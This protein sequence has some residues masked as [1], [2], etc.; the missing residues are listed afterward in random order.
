[1]NTILGFL[2]KVTARQNS[3]PPLRPLRRTMDGLGIVAEDSISR[4]SEIIAATPGASSDSTFHDR[5]LPP[6]NKD[7]CPN[8][9]PFAVRVGGLDAFTTARECIQRD[10]TIRGK[11]A[12]LNLASDKYRAGGW[13]ES[14]SKTQVR[15]RNSH[16]QPSSGRSNKVELSAFHNNRKRRYATLP[17]C[18]SPSKTN[19]THGQTSDQVQM[20]EFTPR[21][22]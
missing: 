8:F 20:Q 6:L 19:T 13:R 4:T 7:D 10:S 21:R 5:Q 1:M 17:P 18:T 2:R 15:V 9:P 3:P 14:L 12:V 16:R 22:S 11:V